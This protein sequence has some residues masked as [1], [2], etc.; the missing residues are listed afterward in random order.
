MNMIRAKQDLRHND[1]TVS[2]KKGELYFTTR[3]V[4]NATDLINATAYN[5]QGDRHGLGNWYRHFKIVN[6]VQVL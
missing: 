5:E 4:H 6:C 2:F 3:E 1:G